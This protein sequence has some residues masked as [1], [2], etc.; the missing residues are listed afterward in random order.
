MKQ[1]TTIVIG[2][3]L[4]TTTYANDSSLFNKF[5]YPSIGFNN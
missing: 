5:K 2:I 3:F 4:F 1:L